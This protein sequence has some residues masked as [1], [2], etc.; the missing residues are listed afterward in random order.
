MSPLSTLLTSR[1][2][3]LSSLFAALLLAAPLVQAGPGDDKTVLRFVS[4]KTSH[5][6]GFTGLRY[7][8]NWE[9]DS[10]RK[11]V[12]NGVAWSARLEIPENGI[13]VAKPPREFLEANVIECGGEQGR[14]KP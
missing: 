4:H 2:N 10:F 13:E 11:T 8:W 12:L 9:D 14:K 5:G 3:P 6:F 7:H 1:R